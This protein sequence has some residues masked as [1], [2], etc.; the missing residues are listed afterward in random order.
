MARKEL[1]L[2]HGGRGEGH[3]ELEHSCASVVDL[4]PVGDAGNAHLSFTVVNDI[5]NSPVAHTYSP[6]I[7]VTLELL[8]AR[9]ARI[10]RQSFQTSH[11]SYEDLSG[12]NQQLL[13]CGRLNFYRVVIH[14]SG[15]A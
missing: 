8:T 10:C 11:N 6:Q 1:L 7:S 5:Q 9:R 15:R 14:E 4:A 12:K 13:I 2:S 3:P